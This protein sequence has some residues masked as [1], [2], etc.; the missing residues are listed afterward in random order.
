[1]PDTPVRPP[2]Q[3]H[4]PLAPMTTIGLGGPARYFAEAPS[5]DAL[6]DALAWADAASVP[7]HLAGGGSNVIFP[8]AGFPG[9]VLRVGI[10]GLAFR[11]DG[12]EH[13][14]VEAG[15]GEPWDDVVAG[16]V[17]RG[18]GGIECLSGI[19]GLTGATPIQNV[20][21]YGQEVGGVVHR[22]RAI[23]RRS[24]RPVD[25]AGTECG[26]RYRHSR[27]K[28]EDRDRYV[29]VG[30]DFRLRADAA[31]AIAYDELKRQLQKAGTDPDAL[32][33]GPQ[34]LMALRELVLS[35]RR[36]KSMLADPA[37]PDARSA[38]S[39][40][41]N[42]ILTPDGFAVLVRRW[43]EGGGAGG[44]P[45]FDAREPGRE[46]AKKVPAA[47]L[48]E[49]SGFQR[50]LRR[51]GAGIS[52]KHALALV[53]AGGTSKD[54]LALAEEIRRG[55]KARFGVDLEMEPVVVGG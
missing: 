28:G 35:I 20:G 15:A 8:D 42:P 37:D 26:F 51:G 22:V 38:G 29:I 1:V 10:R 27:F 43:R 30:V 14:R 45:S 36:R 4:V 54:L 3:E 55:V 53:N 19:P 17:R 23:E 40:F 21:A 5:V 2:L 41:E 31:P 16:S 50:G 32:P 25:F 34:G 12:A 24:G 44:I 46:K 39:F 48:I 7:V 18:L 33:R 49:Q 11:E 52:S 47:W 9:L 6:R 13:V